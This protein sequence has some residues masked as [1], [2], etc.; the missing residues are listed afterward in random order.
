MVSENEIGKIKKILKEHESRIKRL[1]SFFEE[2]EK[3][4]KKIDV[5]IEE[6][7]IK[8]SEEAGINEEKI[9]H[10]FDFNKKDL[11]L[12]KIIKDKKE[13]TKQFKATVCLLTA[14]HYCY[15][16][17]KIK[18]RDLRKKLEWLGIRSLGN[19]SINLSQYK[20]YIIPEGKSRSPEFSYKITYPGIKEGL[21]IIKELSST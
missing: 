2:E 15:G 13:S 21:K 4:I 14:Y 11:N 12:I 20:Q 18:S 3:P 9:R 17:D 16:N 1:E 10:V 8:L 5:G 7:I 19:L 6:C